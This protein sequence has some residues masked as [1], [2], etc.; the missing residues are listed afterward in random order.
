MEL[1]HGR[2]I[3]D[4]QE[5]GGGRSGLREA[6]SCR[7]G[8]TAQRAPRSPSTKNL[9]SKNL[10][11]GTLAFTTFLL[12]VVSF[13]RKLIKHNEFIRHADSLDIEKQFRF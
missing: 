3:F 7:T 6:R 4:S 10:A 12:P 5:S 11:T 8:A 13:C 9:W 2:L 1:Q